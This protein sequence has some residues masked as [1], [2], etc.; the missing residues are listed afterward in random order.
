MTNQIALKDVLIAKLGGRQAQIDVKL[1]YPK[2]NITN[3]PMYFNPKLMSQWWNDGYE[4]AKTTKP[5]C[6]CFMANGEIKEM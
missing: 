6:H 3:N 2:N 1:W 4:H 5:I